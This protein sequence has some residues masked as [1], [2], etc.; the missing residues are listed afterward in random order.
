MRR[1]FN[2]ALDCTDYLLTNNIEPVANT[3]LGLSDMAKTASVH[4][5]D[6]MDMLREDEVGLILFHPNLGELKK[7]ACDDHGITEIN[8]NLLSAELDSLPEEIIKVAANNLGYIASNMGIDIPENLQVYQT[9]DWIDPYVDVTHLNKVSFYQKLQ[10]NAPEEEVE[11][12]A[13]SPVERYNRSEFSDDLI[14]N[15]KARLKFTNHEKIAEL[16]NDIIDNHNNYSPDEVFKVLLAAD[17]MAGMDRAINKGMFKGAEDSTYAL[18]KLSWYQENIDKLKLKEGELTYLSE[19]EK[20]ALFGE[21][22]E[23]VFNSLPKPTKDRLIKEAKGLEDMSV[24]DLKSLGIADTAVGKK[25]SNGIKD[26]DPKK[27][28]KT[29]DALLKITN[30]RDTGNNI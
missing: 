24:E 6:D 21:E 19:F 17:N 13:E 29:K 15:I 20:E 2:L 22:G 3:V 30:P 5:A 4:S 16:Y 26:I 8:I 23:D 9:G 7:F 27:L 18:I 10:S 1:L 14:P 11:K 28:K 25:V 12:V